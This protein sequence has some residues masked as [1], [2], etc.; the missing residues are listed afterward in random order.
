[1]FVSKILV[2]LLIH[3][4]CPVQCPKPESLAQNVTIS[5]QQP[6][7]NVGQRIQLDCMDGLEGNTTLTCHEQGTWMGS[8]PLCC[9]HELCYNNNYMLNMHIGCLIMMLYSYYNKL[10]LCL[11]RGSAVLFN[12]IIVS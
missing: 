10:H 1:M 3:I 2:L 7:Y 5:P 6:Y 11:D 9:I 12:N 8:A 4:H